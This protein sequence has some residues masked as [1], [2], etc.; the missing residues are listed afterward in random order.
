MPLASVFLTVLV[1]CSI[2]H[3]K[4]EIFPVYLFPRLIYIYIYYLNVKIIQRVETFSYFTRH[5][6]F[7][8]LILI[9]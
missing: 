6:D 7:Y 2:L 4:C 3:H 5:I 1:Y 9:N 8:Q